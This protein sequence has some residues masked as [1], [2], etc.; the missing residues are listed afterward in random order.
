MKTQVKLINNAYAKRLK[1]LNKSFFDSNQT[2][3]IIFVEYLKLI[4]DRLIIGYADYPDAQTAMATVITAVAEVEAFLDPQEA[5]NKVFHW[6]NFCE[7]VKQNM[8]E[9]LRIDDSI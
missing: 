8:E 1:K 3:L 7:L 6:N 9:W 5:T 4:R 2:G